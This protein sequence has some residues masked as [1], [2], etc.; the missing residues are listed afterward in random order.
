MQ[1]LVDIEVDSDFNI[2]TSYHNDFFLLRTKVLVNGEN[3]TITSVKEGSYEEPVLNFCHDGSIISTKLWSIVNTISPILH[4]CG[5]YHVDTFYYEHSPLFH[6]MFSS[7]SCLNK[8]LQ[9]LG[10]AQHAMQLE[11]LSMISE[12]LK[13]IHVHGP[14]SSHHL[15]IEIQPELFLVSPSR[16]ENTKGAEV[17]LVTTENCS[18][19][20]ACWKNSKLL[21]FEALYE[22]KGMSMMNLRLQFVTRQHLAPIR[23]IFSFSSGASMHTMWVGGY[24]HYSAN[25][26]FGVMA[27]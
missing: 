20:L 10:T 14:E 26:Y 9:E 8:F 7:E 3:A 22:E 2:H 15:S 13:S 11:L 12:Y 4:K 1:R 27:R 6:V 17:R 24:Y 5:V 18:I 21:D 19:I 23:L 25:R 16:Q